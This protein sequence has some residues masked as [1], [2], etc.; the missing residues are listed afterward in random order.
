MSLSLHEKQFQSSIAKCGP[1]HIKKYNLICHQSSQPRF[2]EHIFEEDV[3]VEP[4]TKT[5]KV[6]LKFRVP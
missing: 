3:D 1:S 5:I 2:N 4:G 6:K